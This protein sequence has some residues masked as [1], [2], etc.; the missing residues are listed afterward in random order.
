M[1]ERFHQRAIKPKL[2]T[3]SLG[4][5]QRQS[6]QVHAGFGTGCFQLLQPGPE[7]HSSLGGGQLAGVDFCATSSS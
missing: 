3:A 6:M 7:V 4:E 2:Y 5:S 1:K